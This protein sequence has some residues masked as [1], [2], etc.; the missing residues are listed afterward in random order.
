MIHYTDDTSDTINLMELCD[1][2]SNGDLLIRQC[3]GLYPAM[4]GFQEEEMRPHAD[5][6]AFAHGNLGL[7]P[8][9]YPAAVGILAQGVRE[10]Y[11]RG[12]WE[13]SQSERVSL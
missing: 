3:G 2:A 9:Q 5:Q 4:R 7:F 8:V 13:C 1:L 12:A 11:D 10:I 6:L